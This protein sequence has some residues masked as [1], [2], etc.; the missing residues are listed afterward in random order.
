MIVAKDLKLVYQSYNR[1]NVKGISIKDKY[2]RY[3]L[4]IKFQD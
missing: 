1:A 2:I 4:V 3:Y